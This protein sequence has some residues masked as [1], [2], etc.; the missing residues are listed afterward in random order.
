M[1]SPCS[2]SLGNC[3]L[4]PPT[5][6]CTNRDHLRAEGH[7]YLFRNVACEARKLSGLEKHMP[8]IRGWG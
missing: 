5:G 4:N 1:N 7:R 3:L 6:M 2:C 8:D